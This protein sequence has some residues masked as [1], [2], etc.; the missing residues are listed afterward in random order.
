MSTSLTKIN[1]PLG[2]SSELS[3]LPSV[4]HH[5]ATEYMAVSKQVHERAGKKSWKA[6]GSAVAKASSTTP[7][8][9]LSP[10][11]VLQMAASFVRWPRVTLL[12]NVAPGLLQRKLSGVLLARWEGL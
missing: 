3:H 1:T 4:Q 5:T 10:F 8:L 2:R 11:P 6:L 12:L 9:T 7:Y